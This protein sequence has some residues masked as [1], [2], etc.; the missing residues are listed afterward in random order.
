MPSAF[1]K[2]NP[3]QLKKNISEIQRTFGSCFENFFLAYSFKTNSCHEVLEKIC[4][5]GLTAEVVSFEEYELALTSG[6][7]H[8]RIIFNGVCKDKN[9]MIQ[10]ALSGGIVNLDNAEDFNWCLEYFRETGKKL[11]VGIRLNFD[12]GNGIKSRFGISLDSVLY[13]KIVQ[14]EKD[15]CIKIKGL[16]CH[17]TNSRESSYWKKKALV[18]AEKSRDFENIEYLDFGGSLAGSHEKL[19]PKKKNDKGEIDFSSVARAI[20]FELEQKGL[21]NL[22]IIIESGT[23]VV[24]SAFDVHANV[25]HVKENG[26]AIVDVSFLD[27]LLPSLGDSLKIEVVRKNPAAKMLKNFMITGYTCLENDIIKKGFN[28]VLGEGDELVFKNTGAYTCCFG[29]SFIKKPLDV[30]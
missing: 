9:L 4:G 15:G 10:C 11:S 25:L 19:D 18:F 7:P 13:K 12:I 5:E 21:Q 30:V 17:F 14:A 24:G 2:F 16:S 28:G 23:A 27:M 8:D 22:K 29:N 26:I 20:H 6:F 1:Y 3:Q